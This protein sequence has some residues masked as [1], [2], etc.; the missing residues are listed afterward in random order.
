MDTV[1]LW[2]REQSVVAGLLELLQRELAAFHDGGQ[3][4]YAMI[5]EVVAQLVD[6]A[7]RLHDPSQAVAFQ[8]LLR[9][10]PDLRPV[11]SRLAQEHTMIAA[12]GTEL[13]ERLREVEADALMPR[14]VVEDAAATYLTYC[15]HHLASEARD[16]LPRATRLFADEDWQAVRSATVRHAHLPADE[17]AVRNLDVLRRR[18]EPAAGG[19]HGRL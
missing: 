19:D 7:A 17:E 5:A 11:V 15:R 1:E 10:D 14:G 2:R 9:R 12:S 4:D 18:F 8:R 13:L 3:T 16:L 6:H